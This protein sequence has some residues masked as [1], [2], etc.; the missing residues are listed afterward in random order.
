MPLF[1]LR[2]VTTVIETILFVVEESI[3]GN[4]QVFRPLDLYD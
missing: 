2:I 1:I 3:D 4:C